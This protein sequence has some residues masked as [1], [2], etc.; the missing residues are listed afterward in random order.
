MVSAAITVE[1]VRALSLWWAY[2]ST[3]AKRELGWTTAHHEQ[4]LIDTIEW[5]REREPGLVGRPGARQPLPLR[6]AGFSL[7]RAES[8]L[9]LIAAD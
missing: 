4:P 6:I 7:R 5:Y 3:K 2:R 8:A 9:R 1:E